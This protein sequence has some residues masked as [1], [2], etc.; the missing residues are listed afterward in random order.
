MNKLS[1]IYHKLFSP[2]CKNNTDNVKDYKDFFPPR[3]PRFIR[4]VCVRV[5]AF[6]ISTL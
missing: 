4:Y 3:F 2:S 6:V 1:N 5:R